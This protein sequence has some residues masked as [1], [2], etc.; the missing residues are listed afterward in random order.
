MIL[1]LRHPYDAESRGE[2]LARTLSCTRTA[3]S[4]G[5]DD[6]SYK[7][8]MQKVVCIAGLYHIYDST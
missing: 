7:N 5:D 6:V 4:D 3:A 1:F 8:R 2:R